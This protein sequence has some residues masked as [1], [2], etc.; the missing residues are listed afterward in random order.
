MQNKPRAILGG[1]FIHMQCAAHILNIIIN[2]CV[3]NIRNVVKYVRFSPSRMVKFK[4]C[5]VRK[6]IQY[7]DG[8]PK[9]CN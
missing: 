4:G 8:M 9:C 3:S 2:D 7:V 6:N 1:E 5:I